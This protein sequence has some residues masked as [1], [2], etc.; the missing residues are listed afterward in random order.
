L[1]S[2]ALLADYRKAVGEFAEA[3]AQTP[4]TRLEKAGCIQYFEFCFELAWKT[5]K[6]MAEAQGMNEV[7][8]P[9][10][11]LKSAFALA[12]IE[13]EV[14]WLEM[15]EARNRM[16]HTYDS[17]TALAVYDRFRAF[18]PAFQAL[19]ARLAEALSDS[20]GANPEGAT[21]A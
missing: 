18:L 17:V 7:P 15:L 13:D 11:A 20:K 1:K 4:S 21:G 8:S 2:D 3:L 12:W 9:R 5:I 10:G 19:T 14:L 6:S 16:A